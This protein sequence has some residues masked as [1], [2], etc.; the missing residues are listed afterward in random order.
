MTADRTVGIWDEIYDAV[1]AGSGIDDGFGFER[2]LKADITN[3][4]LD[5]LGVCDRYA[6]LSSL[7]ARLALTDDDLTVI[8]RVRGCAVNDRT[9]VTLP[10]GERTHIAWCV[11]DYL[12]KGEQ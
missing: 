5:A 11:L 10:N 4:V 7:Q 8:A 2:D 9:H 3:A 1:S 6:P 12:L